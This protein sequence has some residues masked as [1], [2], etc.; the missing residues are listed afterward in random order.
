MRDLKANHRVQPVAEFRR[1]QLLD[2]LLVL[3]LHLAAAEADRVA[4]AVG[5]AGV[6]G[7]DQD[8]VAEIDL[9]AVGVGE[10]AVVHDLQ[11][12]VEHIRVRLLDLVEQDHRVRVLIDGVGQQATLV[13]ADIAR[14]RADQAADRMALHVLAHVEAQQFDA[15]GQRQLSR[16][17]G[18]AGAGRAAEQVGA[19]RLVGVAQSGAGHLHRRRQLSDRLFLTEH[20]ALQVGLQLAQRLGV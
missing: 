1:E 16:R 2:R 20:R 4:L 14:R 10:D 11:Q 6:G 8:D 18:L 7:H 15:E 3:T 12:D 19:D 13:E 9:L 17:L 5:R